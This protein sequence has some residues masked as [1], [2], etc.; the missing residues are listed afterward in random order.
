MSL[1]PTYVQLNNGM[2]AKSPV[3]FGPGWF[4]CVD[5]DDPPEL[6]MEKRGGQ[7]RHLNVEE[8]LKSKGISAKLLTGKSSALR[9]FPDDHWKKFRAAASWFFEFTEA[10]GTLTNMIL[11]GLSK[12]RPEA[13][14]CLYEFKK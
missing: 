12:E 6:V 14:C 3:W 5:D 2:W 8:F 1:V 4:V 10:P 11:E 7:W 13:D 9:L